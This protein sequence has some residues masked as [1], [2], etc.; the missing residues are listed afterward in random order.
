MNLFP[1]ILAANFITLVIT[2]V[3]AIKFR[4]WIYQFI[5][6]T[7]LTAFLFSLYQFQ[8]RGSHPATPLFTILV[9]LLITVRVLINRRRYR[10]NK[11]P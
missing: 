11:K 10:R 7:A 9:V 3:A 8:T 4:S 2:I 6:L 5:G 1:L